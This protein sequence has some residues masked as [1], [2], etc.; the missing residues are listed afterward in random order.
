MSKKHCGQGW[1]DSVIFEVKHV[2]DA[3]FFCMCVTKALPSGAKLS[4]GSSF[5]EEPIAK[6]KQWDQVHSFSCYF[7]VYFLL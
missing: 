5:L 7:V 6:R 2:L 3:H 4:C 1:T